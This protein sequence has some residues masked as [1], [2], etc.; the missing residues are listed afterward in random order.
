MN[1]PRMVAEWQ[2]AWSDL[3]P[4]KVAALYAE[5]ATHMSAAVT[6]YLNRP[7]ATLHGPAEMRTYAAAVATRLTGFRADITN[8]IAEGTDDEGRAAIEYWRVVN[9]DEAGRKRV[10]EI[11][12]WKHAKLTACRVFHF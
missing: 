12:E 2:R 1:L 7:D 6:T 8:V 9:G 3:D 11:L 5:G 4:E 10:A